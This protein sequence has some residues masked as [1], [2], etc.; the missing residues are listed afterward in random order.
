MAKTPKVNAKKSYR[1]RRS[2]KTTASN[3]SKN[4]EK[5][6]MK[7]I[8][9]EAEDKHATILQTATMVNDNLT[10][11]GIFQTVP[12]TVIGTT[13]NG[14]EGDEI[15]PKSLI[16]KLN[17]N[18]QIAPIAGSN[19]NTY[20][21]I[22]VMVVQPRQ[23]RGL[24][25][26]QT[27]TNSWLS[28][29]FRDGGTKVA[30][31]QNNPRSMLLPINSDEIITYYDKSYYNTFPRVDKSATLPTNYVYPI[32]LSKVGTRNLLIKLKVKSKKFKYDASV[33]SGLTPVNY[34]PVLLIGICNMNS[35]T[36]SSSGMQIQY[37]SQLTYEDF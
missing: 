16:I 31:A 27:N 10:A 32:E 35:F 21:G 30:W 33:N 5:K 20:Y 2:T 13:S 28:N 12:N 19:N 3:V 4:F 37:Y 11:G 1:K 7:V 15:N 14:R 9:K 23:F 29:L 22:R 26:I 8:H 34:N 18:H 6:V 25:E 17:L 36:E 24:T